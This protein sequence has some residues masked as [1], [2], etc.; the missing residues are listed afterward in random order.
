MRLGAGSGGSRPESLERSC[1]Q[2]KIIS[3]AS[4]VACALALFGVPAA[5]R[6]DG[7]WWVHSPPDLSLALDA[8][9]G[10][11]LALNTSA[12][13]RLDLAG[14]DATLG[15]TTATP[16]VINASIAACGAEGTGACVSRWLRVVA[17]RSN[18][19][20]CDVY[21]L[22][23]VT[24]FLPTA[25]AA[26]GRLPS[27]VEW[28]LDVTS[29]APLPFRTTVTHLLNA[30]AAAA[31]NASDVRFWAPRGGNATA[32]APWEDALRMTTAAS[33]PETG[34]RTQ[35]GSNMLFDDV[36]GREVA[37][38]PAAVLAYASARAGVG[39]VAA[40]D[41]PVFGASVDVAASGAAIRHYYNRQGEGRTVSL[42]VH[43]VPIA[44]GADWRPLFLWCR[45]AMPR[46]F[47][48][49]TL[50]AAAAAGAATGAKPAA[51]PLPPPLSQRAPPPPPPPPQVTT[52]LGL[53]SC[54]N[55]EDMNLTQLR[56]SGATHNWDAHFQWPYIGM[57]LPP[58]LPPNASWASNLGPG[59]EPNCGA[60]WRHG[61]LV[62]YSMI[63]DANVRS[64]AAGITTLTYFNMV[65]YGENFAC[66]LPPPVSPPPPNDWLNSSLFAADHMPDSPMPG[67][68]NTGVAKWR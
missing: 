20:C 36:E 7:L 28:R 47:L 6:G 55:I 32:G 12:G 44:G 63:R 9:S 41:D 65:E 54:A 52:G 34:I 40:L 3:L 21:E 2:Y 14:S 23:A 60:G 42:G 48:S 56:Q 13:L 33:R 22:R 50:L 31:A 18:A 29:A 46:F 64:M 19:S 68:P 15:D 8:A 37:P 5:A 49:S 24:R 58:I 11:L 26:P 35:Y 16:Q 57:Y 59:E 62:N 39:L 25:S 67:C 10:A 38:V 17:Q 43:L 51:A 27:S 1:P 53:Y 30:S 61:Q 4:Q 66:P 45:G